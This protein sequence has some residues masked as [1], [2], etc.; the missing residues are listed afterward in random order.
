MAT[1]IKLYVDC[2]TGKLATSALNA[3]APPL[4][5]ITQ[6]DTRS[7]E[8]RLLE[9]D[10]DSGV[11]RYTRPDISAMALS[12]AVGAIPTGTP[13][14][15]TPAATQFTWS[16]VT[17]VGDQYFYADV[18]FN[19]SGI[20]S[21]LGALDTVTAY[22]EI[23][24]TVG[25]AV[26]TLCRVQITLNAEMIEA[27]TASVAPGQTAISSEEV[28]AQFVKFISANGSTI[29]LPDANGVYALVLG[30]NTDGSMRADI[31]TL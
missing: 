14:S 28:N 23:Q 5:I 15:P 13:G 25:T 3:A 8:I 19:T 4:P 31:V 17:A 29:T 20:D 24:I 2:T 22:L 12:F 21:L 27:S 6:G 1:P 9:Q 18:A 30:C 16:K 11:G 10:P 7:F 26:Q